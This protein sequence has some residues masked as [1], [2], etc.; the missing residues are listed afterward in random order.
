MVDARSDP[1]VPRISSYDWNDPVNTTKIVQIGDNNTKRKLAQVVDLETCREVVETLGRDKDPEIRQ[2][3]AQ[4]KDLDVFAPDLFYKLAED[5]NL[6]V[7]SRIAG[8]PHVMRHSDIV[9]TLAKSREALNR[10]KDR[11]SVV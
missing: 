3:I 2:A 4:R 8:H 1:L 11:K 5:P 9:I 6:T 10:K 7:Q